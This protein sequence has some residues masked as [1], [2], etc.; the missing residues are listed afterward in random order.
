MS[1]TWENFNEA[2]N[3]FP[4]NI[5]HNWYNC[6][7]IQ[8]RFH[9]ACQYNTSLCELILTKSP[10]IQVR[11]SPDK[12]AEM[13]M[14]HQVG[15]EWIGYFLLSSIIICQFEANKAEIFRS[16]C[17]RDAVFKDTNKDNK[18][19]GNTEN[20]IS[21]MTAAGVLNC[22]IRCVHD[23]RCISINYKENNS[24]GGRNC[25]LLDIMKTSPGTS[26]IEAVG[27]THYEPVDEVCVLINVT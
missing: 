12:L 27:W 13:F 11:A 1:I 23:S 9:G 17:R 5:S 26:I 14:M 6:L 18:L 16:T 25:Q 10:S 22:C 20:V 7:A 2:A 3:K 24:D 8:C 4:F 19:S 21:E 15:N